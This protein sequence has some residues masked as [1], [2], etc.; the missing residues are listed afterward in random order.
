MVAMLVWCVASHAALAPGERNVRFRTYG[1]AEGLSQ[2]T[3]LA[4]TQDRAGFLWIGT[5]DGLNRFDGYR[6]HV[7]RHERA[8]PWSLSDNHIT[9]VVT[10]ADGGL[11]V[12]TQAGGLNRY[13][14]LQDR[15]VRYRADPARADAL[16]SDQVTALMRDQHNRIWVATSAGR[17]QW[18]DP[19]MGTF[20]AFVE[21]TQTSALRSVHA[22]LELRDGSV[23]LGTRDGLWRVDADGGNLVQLHF[24]PSEILEVQ[25][26]ELGVQGDFWVGSSQQGLYHFSANGKPLEHFHHGADAAHNLPRDEIRGLRLDAS[27]RLWI[28]TKFAGL[29][30]RMPQ[31]GSILEYNHDPLQADSLGATWQENVFVDRDGLIWAG[32]WV[33]GLSMHDPSTEAFDLLTSAPGDALALPARPVISVTADLDGTLWFGMLEGGELLHF[34]LSKGIIARYVNDP[35]KPDSLAPS[36]VRDIHPN[37]DGSMWLA[38]AGAGLERMLPGRRGFEHFRHDSNKP[39]SLASDDLITLM[40]DSAGTLWIGTGDAGMDELCASCST[41]R[42]HRHDAAN[43]DSIRG[44]LI[45]SLLETRSKEMWIAFR[46]G[47]LD[48]YDRASD[49]FEHNQTRS[50]DPASLSN[51]VLTILMED[52]RGDL[53]IGTQGGGL[54][55]LLRG[56]D[57][58]PQFE[59]ISRSDG[60][61]A[62]A[63]G[64]IV[65][66][67]AGML[68]LSTTAGISRYDP[69]SRGIVN[70][71]SYQGAQA[72]GYFV[73]SRTQMA[74]GRIVFG[75]VNGA[76][77]FDP[78]AVSPVA[79]PRPVISEVRLQNSP[80][81]AHRPSGTSPVRVA[82]GSGEGDILLEH[83]ENSIGFDFG[84]ADFSDPESVDYSYRMDGVDEQWVS[85]DASHRY[86]AFTNLAAGDYQ[87]NVRARSNGHDW[88]PHTA[89]LHLRV[90]PAAWASP[91]AYLG[92]ATALLLFVGV[93]AW[94]THQAWLQKT[95]ARAAIRA[96]QERLKYALWGS[97]GEL[98]DVDLRSGAI[99][100]ENRLEHL[101]ASQDAIAQDIKSYRPFVHA[102][103]IQPFRRALATHFKGQSDFLEFS[104]RGADMQG[105][106]RWLLARGRVVGRDANQRAQRLV[107]TI[108]DITML[109]RAE[110][111]LRK[112][113]EELESRVDTRTADLSKANSDLR[114]TLDQLTLTQ[115]QL[116]ESEKMASLGGLVAGVAHEINTPLGITVTAASYLEEEAV[117]VGALLDEGQLTMEELQVFQQCA[118]DSSQIILRNLHRADCLIKSFKLI[119]VDQSVEERREIELEA[120]LNDILISLGPIIKKT[121][122]GVRV[123]CTDSVRVNTYPGALYQIV[124]NLIMNSFT[125]AFD[126]GQRGEIVI[127]VR[128]VGALVL[129]RYHDNGKGMTDNVRAQI[130]EPFFT[131]RR[132]QGGTGLGMHIV[133]N[134]VSQLLKGSIRV[135]SAPGA[136]ATFEVFLP[137]DVS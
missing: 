7:Y 42:H 36:I 8:D 113:N 52:R 125:H 53:W 62:D 18:F 115:T 89:Q 47:G 95:H 126:P 117:R 16:A 73:R 79:S 33:N 102:D 137:A 90:L 66:D 60:L 19:A 81:S 39:D 74:D 76:T 68:W 98:W 97:G 103:D 86:A 34:D 61:A 80:Q 92:Y 112:L 114:N 48:R 132:G 134:L 46:G 88:N 56:A 26:L 91:L 29:L 106:W 58:T 133:Y 41:F 116:L 45:E 118:R 38:T 108:Q 40:Q 82:P 43:A 135:K 12:G 71:G 32:S 129:M 136:G 69:A 121:Q 49:R 109:K 6:F 23:L 120:Y 100:R 70:I 21:A 110:E 130:F 128:R 96:S 31:D 67:N 105:E 28:A 37:P 84:V 9:A 101:A 104:Y 64:S 1:V 78:S 85:T 87:L 57:A 44:E 2:A 127:E 119:A 72:S 124:S 122:H 15:F 99:L 24:A 17:L 131:T 35:A 63:I 107:G 123:E 75:G 54:N 50:D 65:E 94:R 20:T 93:F 22:M 10:A 27:G 13:D 111:S 51:N 5:Q 14:P 55:H 4:L 11:L 83:R 3:V 30:C 77:I 59:A 25:A